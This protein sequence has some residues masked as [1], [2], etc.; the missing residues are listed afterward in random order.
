MSL[1][2]DKALFKDESLSD[3]QSIVDANDSIQSFV[4]DKQAVL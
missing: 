3:F 2:D 1:I 4:Q